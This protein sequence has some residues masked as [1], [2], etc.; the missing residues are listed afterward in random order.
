[1]TYKEGRELLKKWQNAAFREGAVKDNFLVKNLAHGLKEIA[2]VKVGPLSPLKST[3][4]EINTKRS[5]ILGLSDRLDSQIKNGTLEKAFVGQDSI[6]R[7]EFRQILGETDELLSTRFSEAAEKAQGNFAIKQIFD[8]PMAFGS[9]TNLIDEMRGGMHKAPSEAFRF[10]TVGA[11][12]GIPRQLA[13]VGIVKG[14]TQ[15]AREKRAFSSPDALLNTLSKV[16]TRIDELDKIPSIREAAASGITAP[17]TQ[18]MA[19]TGAQIGPVTQRL[20]QEAFSDI[21]SPISKLTAE[22]QA[23]ASRG[24]GPT[25]QAPAP[26]PGQKPEEEDDLRG[27]KFEIPPGLEPLP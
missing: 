17:I 24:A 16:Q 12:L 21:T 3:L 11:L 27:L 23:K 7:E 2:D 5:R 4:P 13:G 19:Q 20:P 18:L 15:G 9:G 25:P 10:A 8:N 1:L 14:F 6:A 26:P 22:A